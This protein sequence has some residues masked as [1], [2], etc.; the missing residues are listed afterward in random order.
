MTQPGSPRTLDYRRNEVESYV[1]NA[2]RGVNAVT[3][4]TV[5]FVGFRD[6][7]QYIQRQETPSVAPQTPPAVFHISS[8]LDHGESSN[9]RPSSLRDDGSQ[10]APS[11][12][13]P[14]CSCE[15]VGNQATGSTSSLPYVQ[16]NLESPS[17]Q[18]VHSHQQPRDGTS[19]DHGGSVPVASS[20]ATRSINAAASVLNDAAT[21]SGTSRAASVDAASLHT[22]GGQTGAPQRLPGAFGTGQ[23]DPS[24]IRERFKTVVVR[25]PV[26]VEATP[27][28]KKSVWGKLT[29]L[30]A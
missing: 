1:A 19:D 18:T 20:S 22:A 7:D 6:R 14:E 24:A 29:N 4:S 21:A 26:V 16:E 10:H 25:K 27:E 3:L 11:F 2:H 8:Q 30:F 9:N 5:P 28:P 12:P 15:P 23:R 13:Q 17:H